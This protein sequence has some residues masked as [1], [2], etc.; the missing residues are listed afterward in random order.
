MNHH[1]SPSNDGEFPS[2][3][4]SKNISSFSM[5]D[6]TTWN[7]NGHPGI[8]SPA[9]SA[10]WVEK[11]HDRFTRRQRHYTTLLLAGFT[12]AHDEVIAAAFENAGYR[13]ESLDCP[14]TASLQLGKEF[15]SRGLCNPAYYTVGNLIKYLRRLEAM[16]LTKQEIIARY[17]YVTLNG[18]GPCRFSM[19]ITEYRKALRDSGFEGF[20]VII[21]SQSFGGQSSGEGDGLVINRSMLIYAL[22]GLICADILNQ[23]GYRI[24]PYETM[25]G[26]TD[27]VI[28]RCRERLIATM[29]Q[30]GSMWPVLWAYRRA[31]STIP[32]DRTRIKPRV[33]LIGEFWAMTTEGEGNYRMQRFLEAEG[34]EVSIQTLS[35]W[36]LL[37]LWEF[38]HDTRLR[39]NLKGTDSV[40]RGLEGVNARKSLLIARIIEWVG[41][42]YFWTFSRL[43][44]LSGYT[45]SNMDAMAR[46]AHPHFDT[47]QRGGE[48]H[49]EVA[50]FMDNNAHSKANLT[51]SVKPFG[52]MP[53]SGV[54]DGI[55]SLLTEKNP[56]SLFLSLETTGDGAVNIYSRIQ[57]QL[58]KARQLAH[59]EVGTALDVLG[60][61][62]E[63][64]TRILRR[65]TPTRRAL[66]YPAQRFGCVAADMF[67]ALARKRWVE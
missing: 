54:S 43:A 11:F 4:R 46:L 12:R 55:Q 2:Q 24:R 38:R 6:T 31:F 34:A 10:Q 9:A 65:W 66:Y 50:K 67:A 13:A 14:D 3:N 60:L 40:G 47:N 33:S 25:P 53:S 48:M 1:E 49:M 37:M 42:A 39:M 15:G 61:D 30:G 26:A 56:Q 27:A 58:Y 44:G 52:C 51:L 19:Y 17:I 45:I 7:K 8:A 5:S 32:V 64:A 16:G 22:K 62:R 28:T 21:C 57:M 35:S 23:L 18:C 41:R 59:K 29:K 63:K 20:R 36:V